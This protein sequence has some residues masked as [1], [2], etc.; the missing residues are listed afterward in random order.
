M[1]G[2]HPP[3]SLARFLTGTRLFAGQQ[4]CRG[5]RPS[6]PRDAYHASAFA[7]IALIPVIQ[8]KLAR[9]RLAVLPIHQIPAAAHERRHLEELGPRL[10]AE[11]DVDLLKV[12]LAVVARHTRQ[13]QPHENFCVMDRQL[14]MRIEL[15]HHAQVIAVFR[16]RR[17]LDV[18][19]RDHV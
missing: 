15:M 17:S 5:V 14:V 3:Q 8:Q 16:L 18:L 10:R 13:I 2:Q 1:R 12:T 11:P 4:E 6:E 19:A 9:L 7:V